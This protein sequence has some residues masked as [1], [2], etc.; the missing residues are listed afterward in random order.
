MYSKKITKAIMLNYTDFNG[1]R[2]QLIGIL[3]KVI[4]KKVQNS[5]ENTCS[6]VSFSVICWRNESCSEG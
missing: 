5:L 2:Q 4:L 1:Q 6:G 3:Q